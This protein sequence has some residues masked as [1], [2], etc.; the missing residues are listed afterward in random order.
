VFL[1]IS[2]LFSIGWAFVASMDSLVQTGE[3]CLR[4][5]L[6]TRVV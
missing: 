6:L 2:R 1:L 4:C 5:G 3:D